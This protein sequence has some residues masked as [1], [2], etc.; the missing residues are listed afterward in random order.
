MRPRQSR[1][2]WVGVIDAYERSGL[3][4]TEFCTQEDIRLGTFKN[5]QH[6][7]TQML[8]LPQST[9]IWLA[10][11][12]VDMRKGFDGLTA[13]AQDEWKRDPYSGHRT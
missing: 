9:K 7:V 1:S 5:Q 13:I 6:Q 4:H 2:H 12:P 11:E 10:A 3:R 8:T